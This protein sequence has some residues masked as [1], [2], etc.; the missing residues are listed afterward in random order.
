MRDLTRM[1]L[2]LFGFALVIPTAVW[3]DPP[4]SDANPPDRK[5][6][7]SKPALLHKTHLCPKCQWAEM[8]AK[9]INVPPPPPMPEG[10]LMVPGTACDRCGAATGRYSVPPVVTSRTPVTIGTMDTA[11][12]PPP[13]ASAPMNP[14][15]SASPCL[16]CEASASGSAMGAAGGSMPGH[17]VA[18]GESRQ[19]AGYV[20]VSSSV[21]TAEPMPIGVIQ[22]RY[23]YQ[24]PAM[25]PMGAGAPGMPMPGARP[26]PG[27]GAGGPGS[28]DPSVMPSSFAP[29]T[30]TGKGRSRPHILTH[31]FGLDAIGRHGREDRERREQEN[32]AAISYQP[33]NEQ[34]SEL[35]SSM[36][37]GH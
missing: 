37:Y 11:A 26:G 34:V 1:G 4:T 23:A 19:A 27:A 6:S 32:H 22:G 29:D 21:P 15:A 36:V 8:R 30:Y 18:G 20:V 13:L 14:G 35:P 31:L 25:P 7:W 24:N 3:A 9:G 16:A 17:A 2:G 12:P 10:G 28:S 33:K 5:K